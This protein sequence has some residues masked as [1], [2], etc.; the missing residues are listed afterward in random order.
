MLSQCQSMLQLAYPSIFLSKEDILYDSVNSFHGY[1]LI[2]QDVYKSGT[3]AFLNHLKEVL[4][5]PC[6]FIEQ[7]LRTGNEHHETYFI[8]RGILWMIKIIIFKLH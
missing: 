7:R 4:N 2:G 6:W 5:L 1:S 3:E 8:K